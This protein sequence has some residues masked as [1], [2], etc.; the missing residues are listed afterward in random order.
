MKK[1]NKEIDRY[2]TAGAGN[3]GAYMIPIHS[4]G[5]IV[6]VVSSDGLGW[7]HVS[8]SLKN[9]CPKWE[10]MCFIKDL[11]FDPEETIVQFH[12]K[13]SEY[14]DNHPYCLHLWRK[15]DQEHELP[16]SFMVGIT[17]KFS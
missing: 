8:V 17:K 15:Q 10:E 12:P 5:S 13:R 11:F 6:M 16:P 3:N 1:E 14:M 9:R 7:D 4:C 2:R